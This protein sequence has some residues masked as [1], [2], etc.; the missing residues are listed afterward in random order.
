MQLNKRNKT[1]SLAS[2][3]AGYCIALAFIILVF[4]NK[5]TAELASQVETGAPLAEK[6]STKT[7]FIYVDREMPRDQRGAVYSDRLNGIVIDE[8]PHV[9]V[10]KSETL[11]VTGS[12][13]DYFSRDRGTIIDGSGI[14]IIAKNDLI[15]ENHQTELTK[16]DR[17]INIDTLDVMHGSNIRRNDNRGGN[18]DTNSFRVD[19]ETDILEQRLREFEKD[20][21]D[22]RNKDNEG[23]DLSNLTLANRKS[24]DLDLEL[25]LDSFNK[26]GT[27]SP[28]TGEL[29][30][31]NSPRLGVG[32]GIGESSLGAGAGGS[33]GLS[34]GIGEAV[35]NGVAVPTLGG[36]GTSGMPVK[37]GLGSKPTAGTPG[38]QNAAEEPGG[39]S[40]GVGGLVS[41]SGAGAAAGL[42]VKKVY[43]NLGLG[44]PGLGG[45]AGQGKG[46]NY[47]HLPK[48]GALHIMMH[49]DGSGSIL[50][51]E[52]SSI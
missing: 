24:E 36:I 49:V 51:T 29:Y 9:A 3:I 35:M 7:E 43:K 50:N 17:D 27:A 41:G 45:G 19:G 22:L 42:L 2:L 48:D 31:Y 25:D 1:I 21:V 39:A 23:I 18:N 14:D 8:E 33:A 20:K 11:S 15:H 44:G 10:V 32:A 12:H 16:S 30:A 47:D 38:M 26:K 28:A 4:S 40:D 6:N 5:G 46:H 52:S 13:T 37:S 34:A